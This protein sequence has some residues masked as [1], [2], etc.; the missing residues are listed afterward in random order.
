MTNIFNGT[1]DI[2]NQLVL[3]STIPTTQQLSGANYL[4]NI[5][6]KY[7]STIYDLAEVYEIN[8][9]VVNTNPPLSIFANYNSIKTD[10]GYIFKKPSSTNTIN[11]INSTNVSNTTSVR[12]NGSNY[13]LFRIS[14]TVVSNRSTIVTCTNTITIDGSTTAYIM[15]VGPGGYGA[16][17]TGSVWHSGGGGGSVVISSCIL[18]SGTYTVNL[19]SS[20]IHSGGII[21]TFSSFKKSDDS[22]TIRAPGGGSALASGGSN[23]G[24]SGFS[25][26]GT[27]NT[28]GVNGGQGGPNVR[29][30]SVIA[31]DGPQ[32]P[33]SFTSNI[34]IPSNMIS[35]I[36]NG[37]YGSGGG[38]SN[39]T[40]GGEPGSLS[41]GGRPAF[42]AMSL[43]AT[44]A[45]NY[46][47]G[48][49]CFKNANT[50]GGLGAF[51]VVYIYIDSSVP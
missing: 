5:R 30:T 45:T 34:T 50:H 16:G 11:S 14:S 25:S 10:I 44:S 48:G 38:T 12:T 13:T 29:T 33:D 20:Q 3:L 40:K 35:S 8:S 27:I 37:Y 26:T 43:A 22:I 4:S 49:G 23:V 39:G 1:I 17:A 28:Y 6:F 51:G 32:F 36:P 21:T 41:G 47:C 19:T 31:G 2:C 46:G 18:T 9:A 7:V 42:V 15:V 24:G